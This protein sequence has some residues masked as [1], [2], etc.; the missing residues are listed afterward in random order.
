MQ[1]IKALFVFLLSFGAFLGASFIAMVWRRRRIDPD[2]AR[3]ERILPGYDCGICGKIDC[4]DYA[5]A[6]L[7]EASD[8]ALCRPGGS[9]TESSIRSLLEERK[10]DGPVSP[11]R[12]VVQCAGTSAVARAS[13]DYD[14]YRDC[15]SAVSLYGGPK[16]CKN[17]CLGF[18]DCARACPL[19]AIRIEKGCAVVDPQICTGCGICVSVCPQDL[20]A[21]I[22]IDREWYVACSAESAVDER[23]RDCDLACNACGECARRSVQGEFVMTRNISRAMN[24]WSESWADIAASCPTGAIRHIGDRKKS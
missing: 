18:G 22:P 13:F 8:P 10:G 17:G 23:L 21:L 3:L 5:G 16:Q 24:V 7:A 14:G 9:A 4:S 15:A 2:L 11:M 12:A 6:L 1:W 20:I 19:G